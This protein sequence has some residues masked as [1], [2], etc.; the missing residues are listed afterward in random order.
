[1]SQTS[2]TYPLVS[3][4]LPIYNGQDT[5]DQ[6]LESIMAQDYP[7]FEVLI[8]DDCSEDSSS[9][10]AADFARR[11]SNV[12]FTANMVRLGAWRNPCSIAMIARG[13]FVHYADQAD[14]ISPTF[15]STL[16]KSFSACPQ[17]SAVTCTHVQIGK[18]QY[19]MK[20]LYRIRNPLKRTYNILTDIGNYGTSDAEIFVSGLVRRHIFVD[21]INQIGDNFNSRVY[22]A[23]WA[24]LGSLE[25]VDE[26]L[27]TK[28]KTPG[29]QVRH[30]ALRKKKTR[31]YYPFVSSATL[32]RAATRS[33]N[34]HFATKLGLPIVLGLY[35]TSHYLRLVRRTWMRR[36]PR[37]S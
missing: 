1:M 31:W 36:S 26:P 9:A 12:S 11:Y 29:G 5:L 2:Q 35:V 32:L 25:F 18:K 37:Q 20:Y 15:L 28:F 21:A 13:D 24:L 17:A 8:A 7:N 14:L 6:C 34:L 22:V 27:K 16:V 23:Y 3:V 4:I 19:E 33:S 30:G 10:I